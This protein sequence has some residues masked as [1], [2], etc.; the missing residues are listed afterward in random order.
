MRALIGLMWLLHWLPLP[1]LGRLG[2]ALGSLLY[3]YMRPRRRITLVNLRLC[4]PEKSEEERRDIARRHFQAYARSA[5][6][7]GVLWWASEAR[8]R[9]LIK[10]E[11][12]IPFETLK[13]GPVILLCPHFVCLEIPGISLGINSEYSVCTLYA[14]QQNQIIDEALLKGRSRFKPVTLLTREKGVKPIIR[15][16][17]GGLPF[18]MLP[19]M[20]FGI[21]DAEFVPFF[22]VPAATLTATARIASATGAS[23]VPVVT[24]FLPG[25]RG[26]KTTFYPAWTDYPGDDIVAATRRM[27]AFIE[28]RVRETPAEYFWAHKRFKTRPPG[29]PDPYRRDTAG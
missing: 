5:L 11:P 23:V 26:W 8:L 28:E 3:M 21:R 25:Y 1:I 20:D 10:I 22:G 6:E 14:R 15:A 12:G 19:D 27:N 13:A 24:T 16:M 2:E 18:L 17:R 7:R 29:E 4:F 9:R